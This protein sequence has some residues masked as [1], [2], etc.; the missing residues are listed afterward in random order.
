MA[1]WRNIKWDGNETLD[2]CSYRVTQLGK[3]LV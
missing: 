2:E 3:T 1:S